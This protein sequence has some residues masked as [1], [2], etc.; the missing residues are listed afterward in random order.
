MNDQGSCRLMIWKVR[1][2]ESYTFLRA[3]GL[4]HMNL[5][6]C[7]TIDRQMVL[8]ENPNAPHP[9]PPIPSGCRKPYIHRASQGSTLVIKALEYVNFGTRYS[10]RWRWPG[11]PINWVRLKIF[12]L[13]VYGKWQ[14]NLVH[15][16]TS[17]GDWRTPSPVFAGRSLTVWN[18]VWLPHRK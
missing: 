2:Y 11:K 4:S 18:S 3:I 7:E 16:L 17:W 12:E 5:S 14:P 1:N 9:A 10:F 6:L 15:C 8:R 13:E